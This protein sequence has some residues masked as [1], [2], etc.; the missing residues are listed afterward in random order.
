MAK[1]DRQT[2]YGLLGLALFGIHTPMIKSNFALKNPELIN[3]WHPFKNG[4]LTPFDVSAYSKE[5]AW[6]KCQKGDDHE[7]QAMISNRTQGKGCPICSGKKIVKSNCLATVNPELAKEWHPTKNGTLSPRDVLPGSHKKAWWR[8]LADKSH[9]WDAAISKRARGDSCPICSG[10]RV[11]SSN[12]LAV[13]NPALAKEWHPTKNGTLTPHDVVCGSRKK[14]WWK[15]LQGD[16]HE[17]QTTVGLRSNGT[18]CPLCS[19]K[20]VGKYNCLAVV[21]SKLATEWHP[22][23]NEKLTPYDVTP[24][25]DKIAWW[26]CPKGDDHEWQAAIKTRSKGHGCGVCSNKVVVKSNCL[27]TLNPELAKEWH[28]TKN[29]KLTPNDVI[30]GSYKKVWWKCAK[31]DDHEWQSAIEWRNNGTGCPICS[32]KIAVKSNCLATLNSTLAKEWHP[33]KNGQLT[34]DK[35]TPGSL[36]KAWWICPKGDD[37]EWQASVVSRIKGHGCGVCVGHLAVKSNCLA[38]LNPKLAQ[39]WHPT[40]NG[41]LTPNNVTPSS[42]K[43]VWWKCP[44]GDDH[45]WDAVIANRNKGIGCPICSNQKVAISNCLGTVNPKLAKEWHRTKNGKL[46]P[47]DV[48]PSAGKKVWWECPKGDDHEWKTSIANRSKGTNC[49]ICTGQKVA[50]SNCLATL[51]PEIAIQWHPTKNGKLTPN[52]F[53]KGAIKKAW[54]KCPKGDD[55]EW[56]ATINGRTGGSGCPKCNPAYSIPELRIFCELK[57]IFE[58][59]QHRVIFNKREVDIF[60]PEFNIGIEFDGVYWHQD[61]HEK[62]HEKYLALTASIFLIR[63]REEGLPLSGAN[64]IFVKKR[65]MNISTI[66]EILKIIKNN[67]NTIP[68]KILQKIDGYMA[69]DNWIATHHFNDYYSKRKHVEFEKS[70]NYLFPSLAKEWHPSKNDLLLPEYF[71]PGSGRKVW[72]KGSCGHEWQDSIIHRTK[73]RNCP[74][75][76]YKRASKTRRGNSQEKSGQL[77]MD[78]V[79]E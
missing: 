21:N 24:Y 43:K 65:D 67:Q 1:Q 44:K 12:C 18:G 28:P 27:A 38:T 16:D 6:W 3:E 69:Q 62:D 22:T 15:C 49:P 79:L 45:E 70:L 36:K 75:C 25:S 26:K 47:F 56:Q 41:K 10:K 54:W 50:T 20:K 30:P 39:E 37:H 52:D 66:K 72:W 9:A 8:C 51:F 55:H 64:D 14:V 33:T 77:T 53:T 34:P 5:I 40:K 57:A 59:V 11:T 32:N 29:G 7:W 60:L 68:P 76:R 48:L 35:V 78:N 2:Q 61:K 42:G 63:I 13:V 31:G 74:R 17:W 23:K 73:G 71:T 58:N 4:K 46:T 19:N